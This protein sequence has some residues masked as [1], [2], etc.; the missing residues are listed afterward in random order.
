MPEGAGDYDRRGAYFEIEAPDNFDPEGPAFFLDGL[1]RFGSFLHDR[2]LP[3]TPSRMMDFVSAMPECDLTSHFDLYLAGRTILVDRMTDLPVYEEAFMKFWQRQGN[4]QAPEV[5]PHALPHIGIQ[6][7]G[8]NQSPPITRATPGEPQNRRFAK[9]VPAPPI[10]ADPGEGDGAGKLS[11]SP[12]E[13]IHVKELQLL[14]TEEMQ[15]AR[16]I[17]SELRWTVTS[18]RS[19]RL[20]PARHGAQVDW[21]RSFRRNVRHGGVL[22]ELA[23]Q[24]QKTVRRPV[25]AIC[26]VSGSMDKYTRPILHF[27]HTMAAGLGRTESFVFGTRLT[28]VT[29]LMQGRDADRALLRVS[30]EVKDWSGG[31]RIGESLQDFNRRWGRRV[32]GRGAIVVIV[33]DGWDKGD[34]Y[35]LQTEMARLQRRCHRLIWLN[36]VLDLAGERPIPM[37]MRAATPFIDD[38]LPARHLEDMFEVNRLIASL[39]PGRPSRRQARKGLY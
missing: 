38:L 7:P 32:L 23:R 25:V 27:V 20:V 10:D 30:D 15:R 3:V 17:L 39:K 1:L 5:S 12:S 31:T 33:S 24:E 22:L 8:E 13:S 6:A 9:P 2:G 28:R 34:P 21:R 36:P 35:V 19:R 4:P 16:R 11:Y 14:S 18:R 26:D 37:G 29:R